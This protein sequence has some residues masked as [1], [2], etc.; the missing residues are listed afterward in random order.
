MDMHS[1]NQKDQHKKESKLDAQD[2]I[3]KSNHRHR[4][5]RGGKK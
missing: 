1:M 5:A 4:R 2:K 3:L